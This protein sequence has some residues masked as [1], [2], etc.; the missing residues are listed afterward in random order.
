MY[1]TGSKWGPPMSNQCH[2]PNHNK[3]IWLLSG[4]LLGS[5]GVGLSLAALFLYD[6]AVTHIYPRCFFHDV[7][8]LQCPGCGTL[9]GLHQLLH[10][11]IAAAMRLNPLMVLSLPLFGYLSVCVYADRVWRRRLPGYPVPAAAVWIFTG[12]VVAF[13]IAR[14]VPILYSSF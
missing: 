3:H 9:R 11:H 13:S 1:F 5:L 4:V 12:I 7:T 14:N 2:F 8:G 6:P 10:G